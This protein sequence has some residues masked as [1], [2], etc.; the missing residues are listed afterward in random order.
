MG[1]I[2]ANQAHKTYRGN[3][4]EFSMR[5]IWHL[6][7]SERFPR[8]YDGSEQWIREPLEPPLSCDLCPKWNTINKDLNFSYLPSTRYVSS[9]EYLAPCPQPSG[10]LGKIGCFWYSCVVTDHIYLYI[11]SPVNCSM[12]TCLNRKNDA[13]HTTYHTPHTVSTTIQQ[14]RNITGPRLG[15]RTLDRTSTGINARST[16][17]HQHVGQKSSGVWKH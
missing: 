12:D 8:T 11:Q 1:E 17:G 10:I 7:G 4:R 9:C 2:S 16:G 13:P 6:I 5:F 14:P 15:P 3:L